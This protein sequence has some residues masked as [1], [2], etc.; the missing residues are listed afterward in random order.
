MSA[1][2]VSLDGRNPV[3]FD[4]VPEHERMLANRL[5]INQAIVQAAA[6]STP[7][8]PMSAVTKARDVSLA[9]Q[10]TTEWNAAS[11]EGGLKEHWPSH[12]PRPPSMKKLVDDNDSASGSNRSNAPRVILFNANMDE[13]VSLVRVLAKKGLQVTAVVRVFTS[14]NAKRLTKL[15]G[16]TVKVADL[17][18]K[19]AVMQV[20]EGCSQA[21]LV[22][23]YWER[24]E[25]P[26]EENMA[27]VVVDASAASGIQRLVLATFEDTHML[28]LR[29]LKSQISPTQ[30]GLIYPTFQGM[31]SI[32]KFAKMRG[33]SVTHMF[34]SYLDVE[35]AKKSL[36]LIRGENGKIISQ[37][38]WQDPV[39]G[40][41]LP[42]PA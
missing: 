6:A 7:K 31:D 2:P 36:I 26:I 32:N 19:E 40:K 4:Q 15:K 20:A 37:S 35:D 21:F 11:T 1:A 13:G 34:T 8:Q 10:T 42:V 5:H 30:D 9:N 22:T 33:V 3:D 23:K 14:K 28:R 12:L 24:F 16:V 25:N 17:N 27:K 41:A 39:S 38:N 29:S 18:N